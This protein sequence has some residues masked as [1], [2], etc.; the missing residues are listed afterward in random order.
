MET[1]KKAGRPKGAKAADPDSE[2]DVIIMRRRDEESDHQ[3]AANAR[4]RRTFKLGQR[5]AARRRLWI[6]YHD[7]QSRIHQGLADE[8]Y[9]RSVEL[10]R[11]GVW[12]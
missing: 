12:E 4:A 8:H 3:E 7:R 6:D 11:E 2:I 9:Q 1:Q 10:K 5:R